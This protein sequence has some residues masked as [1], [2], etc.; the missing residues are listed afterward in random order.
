MTAWD[1]FLHAAPELFVVVSIGVGALIAVL[2]NRRRVTEQQGGHGLGTL[3]YRSDQLAYE[4]PHDGALLGYRHPLGWSVRITR[5]IPT[6]IGPH[7][8]VS[9]WSAAQVAW[10]AAEPELAAEACSRLQLEETRAD[11]SLPV[12]EPPPGNGD[13]A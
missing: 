6:A 4:P 2:G 3:T 10:V 8:T 1:L 9:R 7:G 12:A 11:D 5:G 13:E